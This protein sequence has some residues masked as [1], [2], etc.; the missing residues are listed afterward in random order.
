[1]FNGF[2]WYAA[3][4]CG[5][6]GGSF[7]GS[8]SWADA[9]AAP[10][11]VAPS[12]N[13]PALSRPRRE[14]APFSSW[15][16]SPFM[17]SPMHERRPT[18]SPFDLR[19][20]QYESPRRGEWPKLLLLRNTAVSPA[21]SLHPLS[22]RHTLVVAPDREPAIP[23]GHGAARRRHKRSRDL[24]VHLGDPASAQQQ[25]MLQRA[26]DDAG[27]ER[28][29][30]LFFQQRRRFWC[31]DGGRRVVVLPPVEMFRDPGGLECGLEG[32][33]S[34]PVFRR[35]RCPDQG[36]SPGGRQ[37]WRLFPWP[38]RMWAIHSSVSPRSQRRRRVRDE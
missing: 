7:S 14:T 6:F 28:R 27:V 4:F 24:S 17:S 10:R 31:K 9:A 19:S 34:L 2:G 35:T 37:P 1:L 5:V 13:P 11:S 30:P 15:P 12:A 8:P 21:H 23:L 16:L 22:F 18:S 25:F 38:S 36:G 3:S 26:R 32:S 20:Q 33:L 29:L